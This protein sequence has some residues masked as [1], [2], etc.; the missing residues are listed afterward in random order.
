MQTDNHSNSAIPDNETV[1]GLRIAQIIIGIAITLPAF[2]VGANVVRALGLQDGIIAILIGG[3]TL[4]TIAL[5]TMGLGAKERLS[6]YVIIANTF[7]R[8]GARFV[9]LLI[10]ATLLGWY[11]VT[12][13]LFAEALDNTFLKLFSGSPGTFI[14]TIIGSFV[15]AVTTIF[16]FRAIDGLSRLA[17]PA[18]FSLLVYAV[19]KAVT[20]TPMPLFAL[21]ATPTDAIYDIGS[22]AS[23]IIGS[24]MVGVTIV[25]DMSRY[26][27]SY[28]DSVVGCLLSYGS[29]SLV[30]LICAGIPFLVT[31][32]GDFFSTM[33]QLQLGV[34]AFIV[35]VFATWTTN[36]N[37]LYSASLGFAQVF[38]YVRDMHITIIAGVLGTIVATLGILDYF[39]SFLSL[40]SIT[41]PPI[42]AIFIVHSFMIRNSGKRRI[43]NNVNFRAMGA[44]ITSIA[45]QYAMIKLDVTVTSV[46]ALDTFLLAALTY[47]LITFM[48]HRLN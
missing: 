29:G 33:S 43:P 32:Q 26:A 11:G 13:A 9:N 45:V 18:M 31:G 35:I 28:R 1:S 10:A 34:P 5:T 27:R 15:M 46:Q 24:F 36:V 40:L 16:G 47:A 17:V 14:L 42:A 2:L 25:P 4:T 30:V 3:A 20:V 38:P 44:W 6:T 23:I 7:G 19:Y 37:N 21:P 41:I 8:N 12:V 22:A 48:H 39:V